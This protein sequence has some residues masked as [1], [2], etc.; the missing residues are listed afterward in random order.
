MPVV[1]LSP[2]LEQWRRLGRSDANHSDLYIEEANVLAC[3]V[4]EV[5]E[6]LPVFLSE[7]CCHPHDR[8]RVR[9]R[10]IG[11]DLAEVAM[12]GGFELVLYEGFCGPL[13]SRLQDSVRLFPALTMVLTG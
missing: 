10:S 5:V 3:K 12:V 2:Q 4:I 8:V 1:G 13:I 6:R 11:E 7:R 9:A